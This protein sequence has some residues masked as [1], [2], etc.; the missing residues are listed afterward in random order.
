LKYL[1]QAT[2]LDA[3]NP[4]AQIEMAEMQQAVG[5]DQHY[6][7]ALKHYMKA[8]ASKTH[9]GEDVAPQIHNNQGVLHFQ[10]GEQD[11]AMQAYE[12]AFAE[13]GDAASSSSSPPSPLLAI[14]QKYSQV[15]YAPSNITMTYN[16]ARLCEAKNEITLAKD[17]YTQLSV[18]YPMYVESFLRLAQIAY[19]R[20]KDVDKALGYIFDALCLNPEDANAL[21]MQG[22][23][24]LR[25]GEVNKAQLSFETLALKKPT[26][27]S[28]KKIKDDI[29]AMLSLANIEFGRSEQLRKKGG[30]TLSEK[31]KVHLENAARIYE[32]C[33]FVTSR[34]HP[35]SIVGLTFYLM[36]SFF[37]PFFFY[38]LD[39]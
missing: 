26:K 8:E 21:S 31:S 10:L 15:M 35:R 4:D 25:N 11:K 14:S 13:M 34:P 3:T 19:T 37:S 5:T 12:R 18:K 38:R 29:Y 2:D 28:K 32:R 24:Y 17:I 16:F 20:G 9:S 1:K 6:R 30:G 22:N 39:Q 33:K 36:H 7:T 27:K 23:M